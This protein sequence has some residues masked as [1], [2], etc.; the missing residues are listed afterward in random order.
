VVTLTIATYGE[1]GR[2]SWV[3]AAV[4]AVTVGARGEGSRAAQKRESSSYAAAMATSFGIEGKP[5]ELPTTLPRSSQRHVSL[6]ALEAAVPAGSY[7]E[8]YERAQTAFS[9]GLRPATAGCRPPF[10]PGSARHNGG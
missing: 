6:R 10:M 2:G 4:V 7:F 5:E 1:E 3:K 9:D 8:L